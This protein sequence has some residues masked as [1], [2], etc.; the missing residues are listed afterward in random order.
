M[1]LISMLLV[2]VITNQQ[3]KKKHFLSSLKRQKD[4]DFRINIYT[5][6]VFRYCSQFLRVI[7]NVLFEDLSNNYMVFLADNL[8]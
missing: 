6:Q 5:L 4:T 2:I 3:I 1:M 8:S 7:I